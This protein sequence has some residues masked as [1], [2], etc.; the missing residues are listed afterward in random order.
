MKVW[1]TMR[2]GGTASA[3]A[4]G[5]TMRGGGTASADAGAYEKGQQGGTSPAGDGADDKHD[6]AWPVGGG[7]PNPNDF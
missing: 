2:G 5:Q 3:D 7:S 4:G 1:Q 6:S